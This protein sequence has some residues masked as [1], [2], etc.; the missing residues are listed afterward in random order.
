MPSTHQQLKVS[1]YP[2]IT[3][4]NYNL[5]KTNYVPPSTSLLAHL[6]LLDYVWDPPPFRPK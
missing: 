2:V 6:F 5:T 1:A 3:I 4:H